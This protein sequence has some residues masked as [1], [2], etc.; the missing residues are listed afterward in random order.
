MNFWDIFKGK[1]LIALISAIVICII[2][3]I[4][5]IPNIF[6]YVITFALGMNHKNFA[7]W[8]EV[9]IITP[10]KNILKHE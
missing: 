6:I 1:N 7:E 5:N 8:V 10:L 3:C 4:L 2:L 9:K